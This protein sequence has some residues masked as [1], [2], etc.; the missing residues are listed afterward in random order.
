MHPIT[1]SEKVRAFERVRGCASSL[2]HDGIISETEFRIL[3]NRAVHLF[4]SPY[5]NR[6]KMGVESCPTQDHPNGE[7]STSE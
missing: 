4:G 7:Q 6:L 5:D 3:I 1:A 2:I